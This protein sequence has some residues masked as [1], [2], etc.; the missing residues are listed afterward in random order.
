[1]CYQCK[2]GSV[3]AYDS[4]W[5]VH[6]ICLLIYRSKQK[7]LFKTMHLRELLC[8][9]RSHLSQSSLSF[10]AMK[11]YRNGETK[12]VQIQISRG[13]FSV[14]TSTSLYWRDT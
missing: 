4:E 1:M 9:G 5:E 6:P 10:D 13:F 2:G 11:L 3:Y 14:I 7:Y 8:E 12:Q